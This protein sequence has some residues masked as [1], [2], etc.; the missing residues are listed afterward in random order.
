[1]KKIKPQTQKAKLDLIEQTIKE[2]L[3]ENQQLKQENSKLK[4]LS[5]SSPKQALERPTTR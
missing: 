2:L 3:K 4:E 1:M 5:L